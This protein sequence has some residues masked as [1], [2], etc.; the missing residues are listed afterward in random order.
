MP[1]AV[2]K[3]A[4]ETPERQLQSP[5]AKKQAKPN[6]KVIEVHTPGDYPNAPFSSRMLRRS[7]RPGAF[8]DPL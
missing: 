5:K 6:L 3:S 4:H 8:D 2:A 7:Y 1:R